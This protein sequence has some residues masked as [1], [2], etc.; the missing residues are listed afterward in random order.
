[1]NARIA[2]LLGLALIASPF[3][4]RAQAT[5]ECRSHNFQYNECQA[6]L[7]RPQLVYQ[8]SSSSCIANRTWGFNPV[9]RRIWVAEGCAGVFADVG[10]YH[11]GRSD[12]YD[13]G[14]RYYDNR[15]QDVGPVVAG[16]VL[17]A[18][19]GSSGKSSHSTTHYTTSNYYYSRPDSGHTSGYTGCHGLGCLVDTPA[20]A[21]SSNDA[22]DTRP[23]YDKQGEPN[24]DTKGNYQGCHGIGCDVDTP[25]DANSDDSGNSS[26]SDETDDSGDGN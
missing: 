21:T 6:P 10:G 24:F 3:V 20:D 7:S 23:Q 18:I 26:D 16:A 4:A 19:L 14:A 25:A 13:R 17:G 11:Y 22:V 2:V 5:V 1:M 12:R 8:I 9:T 15:G